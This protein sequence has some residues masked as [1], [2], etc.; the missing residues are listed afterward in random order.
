MALNVLQSK[1]AVAKSIFI[2]CYRSLPLVKVTS[3]SLSCSL[4]FFLNYFSSSYFPP[5]FL[6][7]FFLSHIIP[8][9]LSSETLCPSITI[10]DL[11]L[12][13]FASLSFFCLPFETLNQAISLIICA[14]APLVIILVIVGA[15]HTPSLHFS[16]C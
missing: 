6:Q 2:L 14:I 3:V 5:S 7:L 10:V 15:T 12:E 11:R 9:P 13:T 1:N 4:F 8:T 16:S